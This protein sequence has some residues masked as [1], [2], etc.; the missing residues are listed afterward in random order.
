[1]PVREAKSRFTRPGSRTL[2]TAIQ[3]PARAVPKNS[4]GSEPKPR[5]RGTQGKEQQHGQQRSFRAD[6]LCQPWREWGEDAKTD[7]GKGCQN[8]G[9]KR[10]QPRLFDDLRQEGRRAGKD[11]T[12]IEGDEDEA[13][14]R[15][16]L[17]GTARK[18]RRP[19]LWNAVGF[20]ID[21]LLAGDILWSGAGGCM[22]VHGAR[23]RSSSR[24]MGA[25]KARVVSVAFSGSP[26]A[27]ASMIAE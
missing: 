24:R 15:D 21:Q 26:E 17:R 27:M 10:G 9:A 20:G 7:D 19:G 13:Q 6:A 1:M 3:E 18:N 23:S 2:P 8:A 16:D 25:M 12:E 11:R 14:P 5:Q 4:N 22:L